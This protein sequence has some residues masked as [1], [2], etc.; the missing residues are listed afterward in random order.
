MH[1]SR[2]R[3]HTLALGIWLASRGGL[4]AAGLALSAAGALAAAAE[5]MTGGPWRG[6]TLPAI[7]A[8]AIA[9]SAGITVAFGAAL[10]AMLRDRV[11]GVLALAHARGLGAAD[12]LRGRVG[13]LVTVLAICVG[14]GTLVAGIA[15]T[16]VANPALATARSTVGALAYSLAFAATIGPVALATLGARSRSG[17]YAA[18]L[19]VVV[20]PELLSPWTAA[21]LP[22]GWSELT[23]I[24][25]ALDAVERVAA[26]PNHDGMHVARA[27]AMLA[28]VIGASLV[29]V[30]AQVSRIDVR[31][32]E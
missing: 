24:P 2:E 9:W 27:L 30:A 22:R 21:L 31:D 16:S 7:T 32:P 20:L 28:A 25:A 11:E 15:A 17:G 14:G 12:Y 8:H 26:S 19:G 18:L 5:A 3:P 4:V 6:A 23:S 29:I 10:Q 1:G 13:G